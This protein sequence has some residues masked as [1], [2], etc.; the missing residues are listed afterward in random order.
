MCNSPSEAVE[1]NDNIMNSKIKMNPNKFSIGAVTAEFLRVSVN[2]KYSI[3]YLC[4]SLASYVN[5][6]WTNEVELNRREILTNAMSSVRSIMNRSNNE[7][8]AEVVSL[9]VFNRT[10]FNKKTIFEILKGKRSL[11]NGPVFDSGN[12]IKCSLFTKEVNNYERSKLANRIQTMKANATSD[13]LTN[14]TSEIERKVMSYKGVTVYNSLKT[15]SYARDFSNSS[16]DITQHEYGLNL[17]DNEVKHISGYSNSNDLYKRVT[18]VGMLTSYPIFCAMRSNLKNQD[19]RYILN[20]IGWGGYSDI[21][22]A[23]W[24]DEG[25]PCLIRGKMSFNDAASMCKKTKS[26]LIQVDYDMYF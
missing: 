16:I 19:I 2:Q 20:D 4:R 1:I 26:G 12:I 15:A 7:I 10:K 22:I 5:G 18:W 8:Y 24:G 3:G 25:T 9:S 11:S 23:A 14:H 17:I 21:N 13:Y 6:N